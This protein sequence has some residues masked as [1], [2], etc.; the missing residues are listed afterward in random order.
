MATL[1]DA[2]PRAGALDQ[3]VALATRATGQTQLDNLFVM[4]TLLSTLR[5]AGAHDEA[6][7][8]TVRLPEKGMFE[9]FLKQDD[10]ED[11]FLF[12]RKL[13]GSPAEAWTWKDLT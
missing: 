4:T 8:L 7:A 10:H 12:G 2:L 1:L 9:L 11:R 3:A 13:D 6:A 5:E